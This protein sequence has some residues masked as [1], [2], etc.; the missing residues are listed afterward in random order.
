MII[1]DKPFLCSYS[2]QPVL[3][4]HH[5]SPAVL[6]PSSGSCRFEPLR[7]V[8]FHRLEAYQV[9]LS[10]Y[11]VMRRADAVFDRDIDLFKAS[12]DWQSC[13]WPEYD[14]G[15]IHAGGVL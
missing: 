7:V 8:R 1:K 15:L 13:D 10:R 14:D 5:F 3:C 4:W 11:L 12:P 6:M 2:G 9:R